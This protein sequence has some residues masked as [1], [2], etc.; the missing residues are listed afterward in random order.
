[1]HAHAHTHK[2]TISTC[3]HQSQ[4]AA[5]PRAS[6][7]ISP[8]INKRMVSQPNLLAARPLP[9]EPIG[10]DTQISPIG[11]GSVPHTD[12]KVRSKS[13]PEVIPSSPSPPLRSPSLKKYSYNDFEYLKV[14]GK[15]SF[16]KVTYLMVCMQ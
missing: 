1:M 4:G 16:G 12:Q 9:P 13:V 14:L 11:N 7:K 3:N 10:N 6:P 15:G 8:K 5:S 2:Q